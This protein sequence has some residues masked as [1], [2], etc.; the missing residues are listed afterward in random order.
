MMIGIAFDEATRTFRF[1]PS[2]SRHKGVHTV[3]VFARDTSDVETFVEFKLTVGEFNDAPGC[4]QSGR[5]DGCG[6][7]CLDLCV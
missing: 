6:G 7:C 4:E 5:P 1:T 3:R 2:E